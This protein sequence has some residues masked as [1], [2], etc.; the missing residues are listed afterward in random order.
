[1]KRILKLQK[2]VTV[3]FTVGELINGRCLITPVYYNNYDLNSKKLPSGC[4]VNTLL[5]VPIKER[6]GLFNDTDR[7]T[8]IYTINIVDKEL[9]Y[10]AIREKRPPF[11]VFAV[12]EYSA[13]LI[14]S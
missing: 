3:Y 9:P 6:V 1:V 12:L 14:G 4:R 10:S 2:P 5:C 11:Y 7:P 8:G 13:C